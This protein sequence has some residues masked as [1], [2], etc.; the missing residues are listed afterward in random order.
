MTD[1]WQSWV[2]APLPLSVSV[3]QEIHIFYNDNQSH[4]SVICQ[5]ESLRDLVQTHKTSSLSFHR[6]EVW[7]LQVKSPVTCCCWFRTQVNECLSDTDLTWTDTGRQT[8]SYSIGLKPD[9]GLVFVLWKFVLIFQNQNLNKSFID[10]IKTAPTLW[11]AWTVLGR[12]GGPAHLVYLLFGF[13][14][15][16]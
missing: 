1:T 8:T 9:Q 11:A 15:F 16:C 4:G 5:I 12:Q 10:A 13:P 3:W 2:T 14:I 7:G 6:S